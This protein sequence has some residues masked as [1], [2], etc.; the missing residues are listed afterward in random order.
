MFMGAAIRDSGGDLIDEASDVAVAS[1]AINAGQVM[2]LLTLFCANLSV[3]SFWRFMPAIAAHYFANSFTA[4][5]KDKS[6]K[7]R[8]CVI[9]LCLDIC[10]CFSASFR[11]EL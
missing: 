11:I 4:S 1:R 5:G 10:P 3:L 2:A 9:G 6:N 8:L 7:S